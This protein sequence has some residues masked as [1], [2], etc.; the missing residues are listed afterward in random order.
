MNPKDLAKTRTQV[1]R[2]TRVHKAK[3][4]FKDL[5]PICDGAG[6]LR[7]VKAGV[8][9]PEQAQDVGRQLCQFVACWRCGG[10]GY[11]EGE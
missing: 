6:Q 11:V 10:T 3:G 1:H 2:P 9:S 5:C 8:L 4:K 7:M